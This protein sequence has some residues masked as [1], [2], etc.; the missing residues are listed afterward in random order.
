V[1]DPVQT[2]IRTEFFMMFDPEV[3]GAVPLPA[4]SSERLVGRK[5]VI[6]V[7]SRDRPQVLRG[8]RPP[9]SQNGH[10]LRDANHRSRTG[11]PRNH[12]PPP[13]APVAHVDRLLR[14][15]RDPW[16]V[17]HQGLERS[18]RPMPGLT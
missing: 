15:A 11:G 14:G 10:A 9:R 17:F 3:K 12:T 7:R 8:D 4:A 1:S 5:K 6:L 16:S 13:L 18:D 2:A